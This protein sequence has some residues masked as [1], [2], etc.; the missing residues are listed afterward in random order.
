[1]HQATGPGTAAQRALRESL[2]Q[3]ITENKAARK[4]RLAEEAAH[5]RKLARA[6]TR[7]RHR[8]H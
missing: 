5:R 4:R 1:L 3:R 8:G 6:K 7:T 2:T